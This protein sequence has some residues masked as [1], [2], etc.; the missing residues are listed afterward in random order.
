MAPG[1][2]G[3]TFFKGEARRQTKMYIIAIIIVM[4]LSVVDIFY[5]F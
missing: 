5:R 2:L 1:T 4:I 3:S